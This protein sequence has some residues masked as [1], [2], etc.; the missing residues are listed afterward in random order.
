MQR[1]TEPLKVLDRLKSLDSDTRRA[2]AAIGAEVDA[3]A[4]RLETLRPK[5]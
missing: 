2:V 3:L 4:G 5:F 1:M